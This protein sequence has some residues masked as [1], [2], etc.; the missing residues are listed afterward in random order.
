MS[1]TRIKESACGIKPNIVCKVLCSGA[2]LG[3]R[4]WESPGLT[5]L[6]RVQAWPAAPGLQGCAENGPEAG[7]GGP[8]AGVLHSL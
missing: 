2:A 1:S 5:P 7:R 4:T 8:G 3:S 6:L